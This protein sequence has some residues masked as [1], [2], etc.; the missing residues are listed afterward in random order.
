MVHKAT[1]HFWPL[2]LRNGIRTP[3][4]PGCAQNMQYAMTLPRIEQVS[5]SLIT[6]LDK[7]PF[8]KNTKNNTR[9]PKACR[10]NDIILFQ[11]G[12][13]GRRRKYVFGLRLRVLCQPR[14]G[15]FINVKSF[16]NLGIR[17]ILVGPAS[18][19]YQALDTYPRC[20]RLEVR[21]TE[22]NISHTISSFCCIL[23]PDVMYLSTFRIFNIRRKEIFCYN[24]EQEVQEE[25]WFLVISLGAG[26][27]HSLQVKPYPAEVTM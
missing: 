7:N 17:K 9:P 3:S 21:D 6:N 16:P 27:K 25:V 15:L 14:K 23:S 11:C 5:N 26:S 19:P 1:S 13:C 12:P 22:N 20:Y 18:L 24:T 2:R 8:A 10:E 4:Y